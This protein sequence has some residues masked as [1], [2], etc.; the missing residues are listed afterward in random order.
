M[1][2]SDFIA[3]EE[4]KEVPGY[5]G[6]FVASKSGR[7]FNTET[8]KELIQRV[9]TDGYVVVLINGKAKRVHRVVMD[10]FNPNPNPELYTEINHKDEDKLNNSLENLEW[11]THDYNMRY[12]TRAKRAGKTN[13]TDVVCLDLNGNFI[14]EYPS[15][16]STAEDGFNPNVV[17]MC[18]KGDAKTHKKC[19][20]IKKDEYEKIKNK[21]SIK[22]IAERNT[23]YLKKHIHQRHAVYQIS[24]KGIIVREW[25]S[26]TKVI[27]CGYSPSVKQCVNRFGGKERY[28]SQK[29]VNGYIWIRKKDY[30]SMDANKYIEYI[31]SALNNN[32]KLSG[33]QINKAKEDFKRHITKD[34]VE[35]VIN[36]ESQ[37]QE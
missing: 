20:W 13:G 3:D 31:N 35:S 21:D 30:E 23:D 29:T 4:V 8:K 6:K 28:A 5:N 36:K 25:K 14:K 12:G 1:F 9:L 16:N 7:I 24:I 19:I 11:C 33:K 32:E 10:T 37:K 15:F 22:Y 2:I 27:K 34:Y 26:I 17:S 18:V